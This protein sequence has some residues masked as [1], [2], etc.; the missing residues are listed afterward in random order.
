MKVW[1][2]PRLVFLNRSHLFCHSS[3]AFAQRLS[4][5]TSRN[6]SGS[7]TSMGYRNC[8][9][10]AHALRSLDTS[11]VHFVSYR[12]HESERGWLRYLSHWIEASL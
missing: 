10:S 5:G 7:A 6:A 12:A 3:Q 1:W 11:S 9:G 8:P 2:F 4:R